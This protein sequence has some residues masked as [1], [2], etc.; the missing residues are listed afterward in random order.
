M[1]RRF[2]IALSLWTCLAAMRAPAFA[3]P[4]DMPLSAASGG[5]AGPDAVVSHLV[6][7]FTYG[8][9]GRVL[10]R[11]RARIDEG[12]L[13]DAELLE[14]HR[15]AGLSAHAL[16]KNGEASRHLSAMLRLDPDY[17][18][19]P[20]VTSPTAIQF[21]EK[22]RGDMKDELEVVRRERRLRSD[23]QKQEASERERR[24]LIEEE[25]RRRVEAL[26]RQVTVRTVE[27]R[28]YF[29]NFLPF[30]AGQYQ[31]GRSGAGTLLAVTQGALAATS[32]VAYLARRSLYEE[33]PYTP[34]SQITTQNT[35]IVR[36][37]IPDNRRSEARRW[38]LVQYTSGAGFFT[39][40]GVGLVD[41]LMHH[42]DEVVSITTE[43]LR[44]PT[45]PSRPPKKAAV[46]SEYPSPQAVWGPAIVPGFES[47]AVGAE[48]TL[49]F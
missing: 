43:Q 15:L 4:A 26:S 24:R 48:L 6:K 16:K 14:L 34:D 13:S 39:A 10:E 47:P 29:V 22:L 12:N 32:I 18:L 3:E 30:G 40:W 35:A 1:S 20:F 45:L 31:Q 19:D 11:A 8:N 5:S 42:Q 27:K 38:R 23:R 17:S 21:F 7:D 2:V 37:G 36:R 33:R 9:Y 49:K 44:V 28:S 46:G 25:Q 41:S